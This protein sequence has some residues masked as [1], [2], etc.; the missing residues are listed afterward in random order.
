MKIL[1][2]FAGLVGFFMVYAQKSRSESWTITHNS[3]LKLRAAEEAPEK[4]S[5][6]IPSAELKK[7]GNLVVAY[8]EAQPQKGWKRSIMVFDEKDNELSTVSGTVFKITNAKLRSLKESGIYIIKIYTWSLP[9]D[10]ELAARIRVARKHI[11]TIN[12]K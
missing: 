2:L 12:I 8:T 1:F 3:K 4:N 9:T 5:I 10:P 6:S 7:N 11:G